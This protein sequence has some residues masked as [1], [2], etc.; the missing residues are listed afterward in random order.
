M[1]LEPRQGGRLLI[2]KGRERVSGVWVSLGGLIDR[3]T[4]E[5]VLPTWTPGLI[6]SSFFSAVRVVTDECTSVSVPAPPC[7]STAEEMVTSRKDVEAWWE[8]MIEWASNTYQSSLRE[9]HFIDRPP[10]LSLNAPAALCCLCTNKWAKH[11]SESWASGNFYWFDLCSWFPLV[12]EKKGLAGKLLRPVE[13]V[14]CVSCWYVSAQVCWHTWLIYILW[15][16]RWTLFSAVLY[17]L[18]VVNTATPLSFKL[19]VSCVCLCWECI[20]LH[21]E[22]RI[23][24]YG[25]YELNVISWII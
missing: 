1:S 9:L 5:N 23:Q 25:F 10:P 21:P 22:K 3:L 12:L 7:S 11:T 14:L 4:D 6:K 19:P 8:A 24:S 15:L 2:K 17:W 13:Q 18:A 16:N 20:K